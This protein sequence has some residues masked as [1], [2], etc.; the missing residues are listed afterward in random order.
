MGCCGRGRRDCGETCEAFC[1]CFAAF[2]ELCT[3]FAL[4][5]A[6]GVVASTLSAYS[7]ISLRISIFRFDWPTKWTL[8]LSASVVSLAATLLF[9][10]LAVL[11]FCVCSTRARGSWF[12][13]VFQTLLL[14]TF[15]GMAV[16]TSAAI[17]VIVSTT[18]ENSEFQKELKTVWVAELADD[19]STLACR[20]QKQLKCRGF[21]A[22]DCSDGS[23]TTEFCASVCRPE[24]V[25][26]KA[27]E[28]RYPGCREKMVWF[29]RIWNI[30]QAVGSFFGALAAAISFAIT[31]CYV[32]FV[33]EDK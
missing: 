20:V 32:S 23:T 26:A 3:L 24:D 16:S 27:T 6:G 8:L 28:F 19:E 10:V 33:V 13:C 17:I 31:C 18:N 11:T 12:K 2:P 29:Y 4:F 9:M 21:E 22:G 25:S 5:I 1:P 30:A 14:L 15:A 7:L